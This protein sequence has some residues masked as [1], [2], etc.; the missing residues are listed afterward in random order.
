MTFGVRAAAR[1]APEALA[2]V[3]DDVS[4]TYEALADRAL[5]VAAGLVQRGFDPVAPTRVAITPRIDVESIARVLGCIEA[6]V[7]FVSL[8]PRLAP[9][10]REAMVRDAGVAWEMPEVA[11]WPSEP[12]RGLPEVP[13]ERTLAILFTSGTSGQAKGAVLGRRAFRAAIAGSDARLP[14]AKGD[15]WLL[16]MPP[17]HVGGL[18]VVLRCVAAR[19]TLV[20]GPAADGFDARAVADRIA[21]DQVTHVSL[22]PTMLHRLL[23]LDPPLEVGSLRAI[24]LGGAPADAR[25]LDEARRRGLPVQCTYGLTEA[26]SQVATALAGDL[27]RGL[28]GAL[29][30]PGLEVR[31]VEGEIW[32]RGPMLFDGYLGHDPNQTFTP[33]GWFPTGDLGRVDEAGRLHVEGRRSDLI[34]CGGE[35]VYPAEIEASLLDIS[36]VRAACVFGVRDT[37]WGERVAAALVM[38]P[39]FGID[40]ARGACRAVATRLA[41]F[42]RPR[43][44]AVIDELPTKAIGKIDRRAVAEL[45]ERALVDV[46]R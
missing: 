3:A 31:T 42:K 32:V 13:D 9:N 34:L 6:G 1:E 19:A 17:A 5:R 25:L 11:S 22:V 4:M 35:N 36:G 44:V 20:L 43:M 40:E 10:E 30:I 45:A 2:L 16:A 38:D 39:G 12:A 29:P 8:H 15:R 46:G 37:E 28:R 21:R 7:P 26:C 27:S 23:A 41:P 33:D 18:S 24:L 14:L